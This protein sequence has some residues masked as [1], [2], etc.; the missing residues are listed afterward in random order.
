MFGCAFAEIVDFP[1]ADALGPDAARN[2]ADVLWLP[3][4]WERLIRVCAIGG[5]GPVPVGCGNIFLLG[6][7]DAF[8]P[9]LS[10]ECTDADVGTVGSSRLVR[11]GTDFPVGL[12]ATAGG[13]G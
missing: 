3:A 11:S 6:A 5:C 2:A 8:D 9:K 4:E 13:P 12:G 10:P 1:A 7:S